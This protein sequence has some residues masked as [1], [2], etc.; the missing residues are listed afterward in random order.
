MSIITFSMAWTG[1]DMPGADGRHSTIVLSMVGPTMSVTRREP[2]SALV[3]DRGKIVAA[4][5][6][7]AAALRLGKES[8]SATMRGLRP[9]REQAASTSAR[10]S[11]GCHGRAPA[12][13]TS[14][15]SK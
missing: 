5:P 14:V 9:C 13:Q 6:H 3:A 2:V 15:G 12:R 1:S 8:I 10:S 7:S 11:G 4:K